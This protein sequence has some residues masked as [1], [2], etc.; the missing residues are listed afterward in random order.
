MSMVRIT[1]VAAVLLTY[2]S[3]VVAYN[4]TMWNIGSYPNPVTSPAEC[5]S[6]YSS[7]LCDPDGFLSH[8]K[9]N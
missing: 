3:V 9:G 2:I 4:K 6:T 1:G 7:Y 5:G 8:D